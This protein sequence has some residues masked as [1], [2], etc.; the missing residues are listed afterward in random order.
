M[1]NGGDGHISDC[2]GVFQTLDMSSGVW[3]VMC[4]VECCDWS[5]VICCR[6][7]VTLSVL[8]VV[9]VEL[10]SLCKCNHIQKKF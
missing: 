4:Y 6:H 8:S 5:V 9:A 3:W 2:V 1:C 7:D 10:V